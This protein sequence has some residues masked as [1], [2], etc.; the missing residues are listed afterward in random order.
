MRQFHYN[1]R[2]VVGLHAR[3]AMILAQKASKYK[4]RIDISYKGKTVNAK[5]VME[6]LTLRAYQ[7]ADVVF[8][9]EGEDEELSASEL[10]EFCEKNI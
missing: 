5:N 9:I 2:A 7:G 4:S 10:L 3:P 8:T 6:L 1:V